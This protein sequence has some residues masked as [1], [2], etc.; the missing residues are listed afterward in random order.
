M[1]FPIKPYLGRPGSNAYMI[2]AAVLV[3]LRTTL[4]PL[5]LGKL[6]DG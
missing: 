2:I 6:V 5:T 4:K 1:T 3:R